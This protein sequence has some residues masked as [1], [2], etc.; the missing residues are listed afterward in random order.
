MEFLTFLTHE[1]VQLGSWITNHKELLTLVLVSSGA[2][3][4]VLEAIKRWLALQ[5]K[6]AISTYHYLLALSPVFI[7]YVQGS[8][9]N[10]PLI[11]FLQAFVILGANQFVYPL[12]TKPLVGILSDAKAAVNSDKTAPPVKTDFSG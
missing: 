7:H 10:N 3:S 9:S 12:F 5:S 6:T 1:V 2:V 4:L 8:H 11:V